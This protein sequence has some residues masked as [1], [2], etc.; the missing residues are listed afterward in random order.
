MKYAPP[1]DL[2]SNNEKPYS[3]PAVQTFFPDQNV[4]ASPSILNPYQSDGSQNS[5]SSVQQSNFSLEKSLISERNSPYNSFRSSPVAGAAP[6]NPSTNPFTNQNPF[7]DNSA[8]LTQVTSKS[9]PPRAPE[10]ATSQNIP[11]NISFA[12]RLLPS[13]QDLLSTL[14]N[15][16]KPEAVLKNPNELNSPEKISKNN[17]FNTS[18]ESVIKSS[19][20]SSETTE[21]TFSPISAVKVTEKLEHLL[22]EQKGDPSGEAISK[23]AEVN[24]ITAAA[25]LARSPSETLQATNESIDKLYEIKLNDTEVKTTQSGND[26]WS[27][28]FLGQEPT[29]QSVTSSE[30]HTADN[31]SVLTDTKT[32]KSNAHPSRQLGQVPPTFA[33]ISVFDVKPADQKSSLNYVP[34]SSLSQ[35]T[36]FYPP[37][38]PQPATAFIEAHS[39]STAKPDQFSNFQNKSI[40]FSPDQTVIDAPKNQL[41]ETSAFNSKS[42]VSTSSIPPPIDSTA[43]VPVWNADQSSQQQALNSASNQSVY[44]AHSSHIY[45]APNQP[46]LPS[47]IFYNPTQFANELSKQPAFS[48]TYN[49][50]PPQQQSYQNPHF[51]G[52]ISGQQQLYATP[53]NNSAYPPT[54]SMT[55]TVPEPTGSATLSPVQMSVNSPTNRSTPDT[56]PLSFQNLVRSCRFHIFVLHIY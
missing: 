38:A 15:L 28:V 30:V 4:S 18:A 11:A 51:Y 49:Q 2:T 5:S 1:P 47:P 6:Y 7:V 13:N 32:D 45:T 14:P 37:P 55:T 22:A 12:E 50:H 43:P 44:T 8:A 33:S 21:T 20:I 3:N 36:S 40:S 53:E 48:H 39:V 9:A 52:S 31:N 41:Q 26:T 34:P 54:V 24:K 56:V 23:L 17:T 16:D 42:I 27:D 35:Q 25:E 46:P 29:T 19:L 10:P